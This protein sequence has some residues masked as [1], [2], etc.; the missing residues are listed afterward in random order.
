MSSPETN[1]KFSNEQSKESLRLKIGQAVASLIDLSHSAVK[2]SES[3]D[4]FKTSIRNF[5]TNESIIE[6]SCD[7]YKKVQIIAGQLNYQV[8]ALKKDANELKEIC[9][10]IDSIQKKKENYQKD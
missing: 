10:Q 3:S 6:N 5:T 2:T 4:L 7:K 1:I 8:D 9:R